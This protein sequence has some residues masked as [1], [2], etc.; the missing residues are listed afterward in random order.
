[1]RS[2]LKIFVLLLFVVHGIINGQCFAG[3]YLAVD[4]TGTPFRWQG[5]VVVNLD[6]GPLGSLSNSQ[7]DQLVF[8]GLQKWSSPSIPHSTVQ[9]QQ[10]TDLVE[11]HGDGAG[12]DP[13]NDLATPT[14]DGLTAVIYDQFGLI[15][16]T[17]GQGQSNSVVGLAGPVL[18]GDYSPSPIAEGIMVLNGKFIDGIEQPGIGLDGNPADKT[19]EE[20]RGVI[21]HEA[22][23]LLNLDHSQA[24]IAFTETGFDVGSIGGPYDPRRTP[25]YRGVPTMFPFVLPEMGSLEMDDISWILN[26]YPDTIASS[27]GSISGVLKTQTLQP[28]VGINV[29]AYNADDPTS[30]ITCIS[31]FEDFDP[32][33]NPTGT[34]L[35]PS[36]PP[37]SKW[38]VD[39]EPVVDNFYLLTSIGT[40]SEP[41]V[42]PGAPEFINE[43]GFESATDAGYVS[44]TFEI[45]DANEGRQLT[46]IDLQFNDIAAAQLVTE[47]DNG[48]DEDNGQLVPVMPGNYVLVN[49]QIDP[50]E[51]APQDLG[52]YGL[53]C[54]FYRVQCPAGMELNQVFM[55]TGGSVL[56]VI[57]ME[58]KLDN[59]A[60]MIASTAS[61]LGFPSVPLYIDSTRLGEGPNEG[62][63]YFAVGFTHPFLGG[64]TPYQITNYTL[65]LVFATGDRDGVV[66]SGTESGYVDT[67]ASMVRLTGRGFKN[68]GGAPDVAF[69]APGVNVTNV[70]YV[71]SST[72]DVS[73]TGLN[74][75]APGSDVSIQVTNQMQSG[76]YGGR[77]MEKTS[78]TAPV[79]DWELY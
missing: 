10:G 69:E 13:N 45:P 30:M 36:L 63:F 26:L 18:P 54:D 32:L 78:G 70:T 15:T 65:G 61:G 49:G 79:A 7:A 60:H 40:T 77:K 9:F 47:Q 1:M 58:K 37:G 31:G 71:N 16:E 56:D 33:G 73:V 64:S 55:D 14:T 17:L 44:T 27:F 59:Q 51:P 50:S 5:P 72:L 28:Q 52:L 22:G 19:P 39:V 41:V 24:A 21:T 6:V 67:Q 34:Y 76:G 20:F 25:D 23:H 4:N 66:L 68:A 11:D 29:V 62:T 2:N 53:Y 3:G 46:G 75:L 35:I 74:T 48:T 8:E 42:M 12:T 38:V 57:V 43:P